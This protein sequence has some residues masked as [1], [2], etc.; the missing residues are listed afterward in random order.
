MCGSYSAAC[1]TIRQN[2]IKKKRY[3]SG[4]AGVK[5]GDVGFC[6]GT[7]HAGANHIFYIYKV[8]DGKIYTVEGN[9]SGASS[10]IDNGGGV[11]KKSYDLTNS[12]IMGYGRPDFSIVN[13]TEL[14]SASP[15]ATS[16][17]SK[18]THY[19]KYDGSSKSLVDALGA[20][21]VKDRSLAARKKIATKNGITS[22]S[23]TASQNTKLLSLLKAGKLIKP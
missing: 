20:I 14:A 12:K 1:E 22:Y 21:G 15:A 9:T 10:I 4:L 5:P 11:C 6:K 7:R 13:G 19:K 3:H 23:G 18:V 2:F 17:D 8:A 16:K